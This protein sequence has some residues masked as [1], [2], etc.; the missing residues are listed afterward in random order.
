MLQSSFKSFLAVAAATLVSLPA[1]AS[2]S[3]LVIFGDSLSDSGNNFLALN[4]PPNPPANITPAAAITNNFFVPTFTYAPSA[5]YPLGVY[6]NGPVWA[7]SFAASLGLAALPSLVPGGTNFAFGGAQ[8]SGG[9]VPSLIDQMNMFLGGTGGAAPGSYLY[10]VAGGGNNARAA[11]SAIAGGADPLTTIA[12]TAIGYAADIGSIVDALQAGGAKDIVVWNTPDLGL[13]PAV[14]GLG[15]QTAAL[16]TLLSDTMND[17]LAARLSP[18]VGV[19]IFDLFG[20]LGDIAAAPGAYGLS[21]AKDACVLGQCP[22]SEYLFWDGI[23]PTAQGHQILAAAMQAQVPEPQ[24]ALLVAM[25]LA[26][27][28]WRSRRQRAD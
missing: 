26:A 6:S 14:S 16:A 8:T 24:T 20:L 10:V 1:Q 23:H 19:D 12:T 18:E 4:P 7:T 28:A 15:L 21:N 11:L 22:S 17:A 27:L 3:G 2:Y 25:G 9:S 13:A 5:S